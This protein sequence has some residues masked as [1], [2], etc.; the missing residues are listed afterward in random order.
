MTP[1]LD[2]VPPPPYSETDI[3]STSGRSPVL[4]QSQTLPMRQRTASHNSLN[5]VSVTD[6]ASSAASNNEVIYTPPLTPHS[7]HSHSL[8]QHNRSN[9]GLLSPGYPDQQ[10]TVS[11]SSDHLSSTSAE[12]YF[13]LRPIPASLEPFPELIRYTIALQATSSPQ[14]FPYQQTWARRDVRPDDWQTFLNYLLPNHA[15]ESNE[16]VIDRKLR[17][18]G[19][20]ARSARSGGDEKRDRNVGDRS[21]VEAQLDQIRSAGN[22]PG[23]SVQDTIREWND[24]FFRPRGMIVNVESTP[25][26][27]DGPRMP[28]SWDQS[29]NS[30]PNF[31]QLNANS[32][33]QNQQSGSRWWRFNPLNRFETSSGGL[34]IGDL[35]IDSDGVAYGDRFVADSRGL[36]IGSLVADSAGLRMQGRDLFTGPGGQAARAQPPMPSM[37]PV[38]QDYPQQTSA[39]Y[40]QMPPPPPGSW[41]PPP[42]GFDGHDQPEFPDD[43]SREAHRHHR[44]EAGGRGR[45]RGRFR[46]DI[47][48]RHRSSSSAS[49]SSSSSS[50]SDSDS[51]SDVGSLPAYD[52]LEDVQ[53]PVARSYLEEWLA[54]PEHGV[55][56][57]KVQQATRSL[58]Q[59]RSSAGS[60]PPGGDAEREVLRRRVRDLMA[61]WHSLK[62]QQ[63]QARRQRRRE[64]KALRRDEK[65]QRRRTKRDLRRT[66]RQARR[67]ARR[68]GGPPRHRG[69]GPHHHEHHHHH[70]GPGPFGHGP[71]PPWGGFAA[72]GSWSGR[73][74]GG[75]PGAGYGPGA[76]GPGFPFGGGQG[77]GGCFPPQGPPHGNAEFQ[78][79]MQDWSQR[80]AEWRFG[81]GRGGRMAGGPWFPGAW[82]ASDDDNMLAQDRGDA[83]RDAA[84]GLG[85]RGGGP[86]A[87]S[88]A[89]YRSL[90]AKREE[91]TRK[92]NAL[93]DLGEVETAAGK[94]GDEDRNGSDGDRKTG[95]PT[96]LAGLLAEVE[97]LEKEV[98]RMS[99]EADEQFAK[100]LVELEE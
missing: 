89:M 70:S 5:V 18:E 78:R 38:A 16:L 50:D 19:D 64:R 29:F 99:I 1:Q 6:D 37:P 26:D 52:D 57:E 27:R 87:R 67:E 2:D 59:A 17:G 14:D 36:R 22:C 51:E 43:K 69:D 4:G 71:P 23:Q 46:R 55:T 96:T 34:R 62:R 3:Y 76:R 13:E 32:Y 60:P 44:D 42:P 91:L 92:R 49:S 100:E 54:H 77:R 68:G 10:N 12:A 97:E 82:P 39:Y 20:N 81:G 35:S 41:P 90:E 75:F 21:P 28:G 65:R 48:Q 80:L 25:S 66:E 86:H 95:A 98:E 94:T 72:R 40:A 15:A 79:S 61:Q 93:A 33:S 53:L 45:G 11:V 7:S 73:R 63:K 9:S 88:A 24:G 31:N 58:G 85:V 83:G 74:G 56:R 84:T 47:T 30:S 8:G